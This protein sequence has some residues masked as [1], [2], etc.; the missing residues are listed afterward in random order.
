MHEVLEVLEV[1]IAVHPPSTLCTLRT[2]SS[3]GHSLTPAPCRSQ[4]DQCGAPHLCV[5]PIGR[6]LTSKEAGAKAP[7]ACK[8]TDR[9]RTDPEPH[10]VR[11]FLLSRGLEPEAEVLLAKF[12][13]ADAATAVV[14]AAATAAITAAAVAAAV[15][16]A[17][18]APAAPT[19]AA[20]ALAEAGCALVPKLTSIDWIA[21]ALP[22]PNWMTLSAP[23]PFKAD[24]P[25]LPGWQLGET[26]A[27][28]STSRLRMV[29]WEE[30]P[31]PK[32]SEDVLGEA[33][34]AAREHASP[35]SP[36]DPAA[37][38]PLDFWQACGHRELWR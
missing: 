1:P 24:A 37:Q 18:A 10:Q 34:V 9:P 28:Q 20:P 38:P 11:A 4:P 29:S 26:A 17:S 23:T 14:V 31:M 33:A 12:A 27:H 19:P 30:H 8:R 21:T 35:T 32:L 7:H 22:D 5:A 15:A 13:G 3:T 6:V 16:A 36:A 2:P 25:T